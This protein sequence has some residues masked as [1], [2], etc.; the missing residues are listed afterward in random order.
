MQAKSR[1]PLV[2]TLASLSLLM[3]AG[4]SSK[5]A[6]STPLTSNRTL[7]VDE[8]F[9]YDDLDPANAV[10]PTTNFVDRATYDTLTVVNAHDLSKPYPSLA[11]S[12][13]VSADAKTTTFH[14]RH[15]VKFASGNPLTSADVVWSLNRLETVGVNSGQNYVA[16]DPAG[17]NFTVAA[18]DPYTVVVT[19]QVADPAVA[20]Q[21]T[22]LNASILDSKLVEQHG[23]TDNKNDQAD[24]FLNSASAGSGP[25]IAQSVDRTSQIE[26]KANP[27]YWGVKP[28]FPTVILRN[29]P[30]ATQRFDVQ[31]GQA[32]VAIDIPVSDA[33]SMDQS[34]VSVETAPSADQTYI[35]LNADPKVLPWTSDPK[36]RDAVRYALTYKRLVS[37]AGKGTVEGTGFIPNGILG[38]LPLSDAPKQDL[39]RAR[40]D[41]SSVTPANPTFTLEYP[42]DLSADGHLLEP[43]AEEI[44]SDLKAVGITVNLLGEPNAIYGSKFLTGKVQARIGFNYGDYPDPLA[45]DPINAV[46]PGAD[47]AT[48][49]WVQGMDPSLDALTEAALAAITPTDRNTAYQAVERA[50]NAKAYFDFI[51]QPSRVVVLAEGI[52]A[53][54]NPFTTVSLASIT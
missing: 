29:A 37:L 36:F 50:M 53:T 15:G 19:T 49:N 44:Q 7:V 1:R 3:A 54:V 39:A 22:M 32:Q 25:Y 28:T 33:S 13:Q 16:Q 43:F 14:L 34:K 11:T 41:M 30:S 38:A 47:T 2:V 8:N 45:Y 20:M 5:G 9:N 40:A 46:V 4:C 48:D 31:D 10:F 51:L 17:N 42:S 52:H 21:M 6:G 26:L 27:H 12:W 23:G 18:P 35:M 24:A